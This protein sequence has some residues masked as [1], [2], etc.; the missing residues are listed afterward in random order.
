MPKDFNHLYSI[1]IEKWD[2]KEAIDSVN[3]LER[4]ADSCEKIWRK[5]ASFEKR[6]EYAILKLEAMRH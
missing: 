6:F 3:A 1:I 2:E 5:E 4:I